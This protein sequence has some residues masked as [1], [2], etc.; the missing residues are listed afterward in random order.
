MSEVTTGMR[1]KEIT[2]M[3]WINKEKKT[4]NNKNNSNSRHIYK[5]N[6][7]LYILIHVLKLIK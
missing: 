4:K 6:P 1:E 7:H 3:E 5:K 2:S